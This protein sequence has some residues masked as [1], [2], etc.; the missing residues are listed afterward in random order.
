[1]WE[2]E[3]LAIYS[4]YLISSWTLSAECQVYRFELNLETKRHEAA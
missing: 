4:P 2:W 1:M 3:D